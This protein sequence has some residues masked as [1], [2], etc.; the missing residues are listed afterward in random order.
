MSILSL[1]LYGS[2]ARGDYD[3]ESDTDLFA[4]TSDPDY[5]MIVEGK[6]NIACYPKMQAYKRAAGGDLYFMHI[7]REGIVLYD[8]DGD[9]REIKRSF[10][11]KSSYYE[12]REAATSLGFALVLNEAGTKNFLFFN[13]RLVWCIRTM[14]IAKTAEQGD[15]LFSAEAL[16]KRFNDS[17][18]SDFIK[19][20][21]SALYEKKAY[22][23]AMD[24]LV[25]YGS[26]VPADM[27]RDYSSLIGYF[28]R[29]HNEVGVKTAKLL[30]KDV[31]TG[32][33]EWLQ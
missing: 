22:R 9:F 19:I 13:K 26:P 25:Q 5:R 29:R 33:Y 3:S 6:T 18:I 30:A 28:E 4:I 1:S 7:V 15:P 24:L 17:R 23:I 31:D 12:E 16:A 8:N 32:E 2:R 14:L 20:K 10:K 11:F 21:S 27:P